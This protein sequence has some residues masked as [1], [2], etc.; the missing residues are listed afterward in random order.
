MFTESLK[1][2]KEYPLSQGDVLKMLGMKE[3]E[4]E[5]DKAEVDYTPPEFI[6]LLFTDIGIFTPAAV[7]DELLQF[8]AKN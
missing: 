4:L 3:G 6:S 5:I 7:S 1:F 2:I 8:F